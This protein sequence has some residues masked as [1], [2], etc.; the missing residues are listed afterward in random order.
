MPPTS[1]QNL[2]EAII[3]CF[4][5]HVPYS[6]LSVKTETTPWYPVIWQGSWLVTHEAEIRSLHNKA[7]SD[8]MFVMDFMYKHQLEMLQIWHS[9]IIISLF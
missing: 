9:A 7:F 6:N 5:V 3:P 1:L 2:N 4:S 8:K